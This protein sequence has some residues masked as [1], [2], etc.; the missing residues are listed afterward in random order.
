[1]W[2]ER[3]GPLAL[4]HRHAPAHMWNASAARTA[5]DRAQRDMTRTLMSQ[6][7]LVGVCDSVLVRAVA[8]AYPK[9]RGSQ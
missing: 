1:M 7:T 4:A 8:L 6:R 9:S 3:E 2:T 5:A